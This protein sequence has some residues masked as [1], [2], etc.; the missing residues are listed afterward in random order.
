[1]L[2][3]NCFVML[4]LSP[5]LL[6]AVVLQANPQCVDCG[7][8]SPDWAS[9]NLGVMMC[10]ECSGIHRSMGVHISKVHINHCT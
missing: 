3:R 10:I 6:T 8:V 2:T 7:A 9:I 1:M 5:L 4:I